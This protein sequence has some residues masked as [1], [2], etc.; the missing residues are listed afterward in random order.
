MKKIHIVGFPPPDTSSNANPSDDYWLIVEGNSFGDQML[1]LEYRRGDLVE[2]I[3]GELNHEGSHRNI[4][5]LESY[6]YKLATKHH[7]GV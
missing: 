2:T 3:W 4:L 5:A 7:K 1:R 6:L